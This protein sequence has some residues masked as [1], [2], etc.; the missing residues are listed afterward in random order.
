MKKFTFLF[1]LV[2]F[3]NASAQ[4]YF[5]PVGSKSR[6]LADVSVTLVEPWAAFNNQAALA[7]LRQPAIGVFAENRFGL[8]ELNGG[9]A[10][11]TYPIAKSGTLAVDL[12]IFNYSII[13]SRQKIGIAYGMQLAKYVLAGL[14]LN[15]LRTYTEDYGNR[16]V[17]CGEAGFLFPVAK[18]TAFGIHVFNPTAVKY[19]KNTNEQI[20]VIV[21]IGGH[22]KFD[23]NVTIFLEAEHSNTYGYGAKGAIEYGFNKNFSIRMGL[24]NKPVI[25]AFGIN[26]VFKKFT[27]DLAMQFHQILGSTPSLSAFHYFG[28][29][30]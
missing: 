27:V 18:N 3:L 15:Y 16:S 19:S 6:G 29:N 20:P 12:Y 28:E 4:E 24:R 10:S 23:E 11:F 22:Y 25:A 13:Y 21:N 17:I 30:L 8:K 14:Q 1:F 7:L 26:F 9:A 2:L 5:N